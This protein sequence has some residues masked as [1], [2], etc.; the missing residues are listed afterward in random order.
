MIHLPVWEDQDRLELASD[1]RRLNCLPESNFQR[2]ESTFRL[3]ES[4]F[5]DH[6]SDYRKF[7]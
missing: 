6:E 1:K 3:S 5:R 7:S 4:P 2:S